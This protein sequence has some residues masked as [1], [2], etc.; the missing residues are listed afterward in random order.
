MNRLNLTFHGVGRPHPEIDPGEEHFWVGEGDL[1]A[2]LDVVAG[3]TDVA[4]T[5]DD[6]NASDAEIV[7]PQLI[8][9]G[10]TA[11][12]FIVGERLGRPGYLDASDVRQLVEHGMQV[13]AHGMAHVDWRTLDDS[14][15]S[16]E[17]LD[18]RR[19][20]EAASGELPSSA[21]CPFGAYDRRVLRRARDAGYERI[22]TSDGG[23]ANASAWLQPR[24]TLLRG[25]GA[26]SVLRLLQP[27]H[28]AASVY[29]TTRR[30]VKRWR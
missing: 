8:A 18:V 24:N 9:R 30:L 16:R 13:G 3:R 1:A 28:R 25:D 26:A 27:A 29:I 12:F 4:L 17:L 20:L 14:V 10:L 21:S 6:G 5:F 2:V 23:W 7:L 19:V 15:L 22:Y 11:T